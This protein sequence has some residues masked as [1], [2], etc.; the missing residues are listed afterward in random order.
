MNSIKKLQIEYDLLKNQYSKA[1]VTIIRF[2]TVL[3][4]VLLYKEGII[5]SLIVSFIIDLILNLT[6]IKKIKKRKEEIL[7]WIKTK[8][9]YTIIK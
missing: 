8:N 9:N 3:S 6:L 5:T 4:V 1:E 2:L 7:K